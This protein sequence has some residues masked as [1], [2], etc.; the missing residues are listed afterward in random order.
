MGSGPKQEAG[1]KTVAGEQEAGGAWGAREFLEKPPQRDRERMKIKPGSPHDTGAPFGMQPVCHLRNG[2]SSVLSTLA[3]PLQS[4]GRSPSPVAG[5]R[6]P[7][8]H[9]TAM[10]P[11]PGLFSGPR[12]L[13]IPVADCAASSPTLFFSKGFLPSCYSFCRINF[14]VK[15]SRSPRPDGLCDVGAGGQ[16]SL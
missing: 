5:C 14:I 7:V 13:L 10:A 11:F 15:L 9:P 4:T 2:S 6:S 1:T 16:V 12:R 8:A 3:R